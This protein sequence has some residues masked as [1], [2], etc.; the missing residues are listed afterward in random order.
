M[1]AEA[2][3]A[4]YPCYLEVGNGFSYSRATGNLSHHISVTLPKCA[5]YSRSSGQSGRSRNGG[6]T[7]NGGR[8]KFEMTSNEMMYTP[9][10]TY[11][12]TLSSYFPLII[13]LEAYIKHHVGLEG[14]NQVIAVPGPASLV[15][16]L[17]KTL[18]ALEKQGVDEWESDC[19]QEIGE[20]FLTQ[21]EVGPSFTNRYDRYLHRLQLGMSACGSLP[22]PDRETTGKA[23][24]TQCAHGWFPRKSPK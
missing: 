17:G 13:T 18:V 1:I 22:R 16:F 10:G 23:Q 4:C 12:P 19:R 5:E 9:E 24:R 20:V 8:T 15:D 6:D 2:R 14:W 21:Q 3:G 11:H 7:V